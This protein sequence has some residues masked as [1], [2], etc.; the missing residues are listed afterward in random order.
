MRLQLRVRRSL[1][2]WS[3]VHGIWSSCALV[4]YMPLAR[5]C[6][7]NDED[8]V[9]S[10]STARCGTVA[11]FISRV[12]RTIPQKTK[13]RETRDLRPVGRGSTVNSIDSEQLQNMA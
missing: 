5:V 11:V 3:D 4:S 9:S 1:V 12:Y 10:P 8:R 7:N 13:A 6:S 2:I